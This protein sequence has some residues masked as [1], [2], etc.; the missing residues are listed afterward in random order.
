VARKR[1]HQNEVFGLSFLDVICCGF[2]AVVLLLVIA[3]TAEPTL[4][5]AQGQGLENLA[6]KLA[7]WLPQLEQRRQSLEQQLA[8]QREQ[9]AAAHSR[10]ARLELQV[11]AAEAER[12]NQELEAEAAAVIEQRLATA[13]QALTAEM[14]RLYRAG[15]QYSNTAVAGIPVDSEYIIFV[16]DTSGSMHSYAWPLVVEKLREALSVYP[17]VKGLQVMNDEGDYM[18]SQYTGQWIPDTPGRR[19]VILEQLATWQP[20]SDSNPVEGIIEALRAFYDPNKRISIY[21]FGDEF[22][23]G[24]IQSVLDTVARINPRDNRGNLRVRIHGVGFPTQ[25]IDSGQIL[26]TGIRFATLMRN[27]CEANGGTFVGLQSLQ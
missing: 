3:K 9:R 26:P 17:E 21:V 2:G 4:I 25:F 12:A 16:I 5:A 15:Y 10:L 6:S 1:R 13:K 19:Q 11:A 7:D 20:F 18:F 14:E 24:S 22:T 8:A 27:L 23:G